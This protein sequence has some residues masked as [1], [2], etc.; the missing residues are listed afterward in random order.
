MDPLAAVM[1]I[2]SSGLEAQ[3]TR[4]R[5]VA[6]NLANAQSTGTTL[7]Q[8]P[9]RERQFHLNKPS[10]RHRVAIWSKLERSTE[11]S[12]RSKWNTIPAIRPRMR[13]VM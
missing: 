13:R 3:S 12:R 1:K 6:E 5:I 2:A 10:I 7:A 4:L 8:I 9:M 11:I